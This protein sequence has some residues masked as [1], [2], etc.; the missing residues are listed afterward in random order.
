L[1][2]DLYHTED[3]IYKLSL[4][5]EPRNSKSWAS[6]VMPKPDPTVINKHIRKLV[7]NVLWYQPRY[8]LE[9]IKTALWQ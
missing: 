5:L 9:S 4:V 1:S 2:L 3:D 8:Q 6:G 7:E